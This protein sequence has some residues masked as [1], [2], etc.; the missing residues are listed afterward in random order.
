MSW[1]RKRQ[2]EPRPAPKHASLKRKDLRRSLRFWAKA[3]WETPVTEI[4]AYGETKWGNPYTLFLCGELQLQIDEL[5][6][7][8]HS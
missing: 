3:N 4:P 6:K 8:K 7:E 2:E 5:K 1:F